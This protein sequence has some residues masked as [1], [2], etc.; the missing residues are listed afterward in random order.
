MGHLWGET[1]EEEEGEETP[2]IVSCGASHT[3]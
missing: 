1:E 2:I 3:R